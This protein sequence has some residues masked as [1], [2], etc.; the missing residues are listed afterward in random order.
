MIIDLNQLVK[1]G[2]LIAVV[3]LAAKYDLGLSMKF[4]IE[5]VGE[6]ELVK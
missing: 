3:Y 6:V 2:T 1:A 5:G 4:E